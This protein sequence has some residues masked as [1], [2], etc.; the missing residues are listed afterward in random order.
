[1]SACP[2]PPPSPL[3]SGQARAHAWEIER[4]H[5]AWQAD[6]SISTQVELS[7]LLQ[8]ARE[9]FDL[10]VSQA[11]VAATAAAA[12]LESSDDDDDNDDSGD[13]AKR[14]LKAST[15]APLPSSHGN[16]DF[17]SKAVDVQGATE[18]AKFVLLGWR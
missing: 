6:A 12:A 5:A 10:V 17:E 4:E 18:V 3:P 11:Q 9:K 13:D 14:E 7:F 2:P 16:T 1:M 15:P 8:L